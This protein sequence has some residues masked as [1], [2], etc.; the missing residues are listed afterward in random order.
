[1]T[2]LLPYL[3]VRSPDGGERTIQLTKTQY[4]IGR[5]PANDIDLPDD[6]PV[7]TR[8]QHCILE[9]EGTLWYLTDT[10]RNGTIW[11]REEQQV[12]VQSRPNARIQI[13]SGDVIHIHGWELAFHDPNETSQL[14][15]RAKS[16]LTCPLVYK[17]KQA[18]LYKVDQGQLQKVDLR[19]Q[20]RKMLGYMAENNLKNGE[21]RLC[22][23]KEL[24]THIWGDD[25]FDY[26]RKNQD[27]N[28][29]AKDIRHLFKEQL[30][31]EDKPESL[32]ETIKNEGYILWIACEP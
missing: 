23:Y 22:T 28:G 26:D 14:L 8:I 30:Q 12:Q 21:P 25:A 18:T 17:L 31:P 4:K 7:I 13:R 27:I 32:L 24:I 6:R 19:P 9:R 2:S 3:M 5:F 11:Q 16:K 10:S 29:L 15:V 20:V 1:M